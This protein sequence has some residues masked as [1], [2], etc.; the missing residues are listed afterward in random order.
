MNQWVLRTGVSVVAN[1][2][3]LLVAALL[4]SNF[5]IEVLPFIVMAVI[6]TLATMLIKPVA[7]SLAGKFASGATWISGLV[8]VALGLI[9]AN[10]LAGSAI[11]I[12]GLWNAWIFAIVIVWLGTLAYDLIDDRVVAEVTKRVPGAGESGSATA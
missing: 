10:A 11:D 3:A 7:E 8:T 1:A 9:I 6:F 12:S 2:L 4:L 5:E